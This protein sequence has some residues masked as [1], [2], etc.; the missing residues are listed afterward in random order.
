MNLETRPCRPAARRMTALGH[1]PNRPS[2][3]DDPAVIEFARDLEQ[4][5]GFNADELML[6]QFADPAERHGS[7][8]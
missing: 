4:R 8:S 2:F 1:A 6:G 3:A 5:H 7:A